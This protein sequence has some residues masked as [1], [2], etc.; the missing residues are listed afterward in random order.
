MRHS[1]RWQNC[2]TIAAFQSRAVALSDEIRRKLIAQ[3][4]AAGGE[5][6]IG[7]SKR[8]GD[9]RRSPIADAVGADL[10]RIR[11]FP[12]A[13]WRKLARGDFSVT[14]VAGRLTDAAC[15]HL[16]S[17]TFRAKIED[18]REHMRQNAAAG[19]ILIIGL[20]ESAPFTILDGNHRLVA[21]LLTSPETV[22]RLRF[23]CGLSPRKA[24]GTLFLSRIVTLPCNSE[25]TV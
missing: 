3:C 4:G 23:F 22:C 1:E 6:M 16:T 19:A 15:R 21:A 25:T 12:R 11:V 14:Q 7:E 20:S 17:Q 2:V 13:Q 8:S 24:T 10:H 9:V 5:P 18:L